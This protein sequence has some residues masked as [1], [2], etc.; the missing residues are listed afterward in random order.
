[1]S[2]VGSTV[3]VVRGLGTGP[4]EREGEAMTLARS[5]CEHFGGNRRQGGGRA[6][7]GRVGHVGRL[8]GPQADGVERGGDE[9][10]FHPGGAEPGRDR[11]PLGVGTDDGHGTVGGR[12]QWQDAPMVLQ[13]DGGS[14][15][16]LAG[17]RGVLG[18]VDRV[19]RGTGRISTDHAVGE[20]G[21]EHTLDRLVDGRHRQE[22]PAN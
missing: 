5:G 20:H 14:C 18:G 13:Q 2:T 16:H 11:I 1:M 8:A 9:R 17:Q 19:A 21:G 7:T 3:W 4:Y 10:G 6:P 15:R 12:R 22:A